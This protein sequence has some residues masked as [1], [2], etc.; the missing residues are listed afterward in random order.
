MLGGG[1]RLG[2]AYEG[3]RRRRGKK[4]ARSREIKL[5]EGF[6]WLLIYGGTMWAISVLGAVKICEWNNFLDDP[7]RAWLGMSL[8]HCVCLYWEL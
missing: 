6:K 1:P 8:L 7:G 2:L 3:T 5:I 4:E